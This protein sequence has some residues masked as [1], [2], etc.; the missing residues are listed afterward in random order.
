MES[1][2]LEESYVFCGFCGGMVYADQPICKKCGLEMSSA[3]VADLA[4]MEEGNIKALDEIYKLRQISTISLIITIAGFLITLALGFNFFFHLYFWMAIANIF[5][6][7]V[8]W[9]N[10]YATLNFAF[11]DI[12]MIKKKK[13]EILF[14]FFVNL[15]LGLAFNI[16]LLS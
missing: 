8:G 4:K 14:L 16:Y 7:F 5:F 9:N 3:G 15:I 2:K 12:E 6:G 13:K 10:K 1:I 11:E